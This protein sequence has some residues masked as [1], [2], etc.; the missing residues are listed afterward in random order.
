MG[1]YSEADFIICSVCASWSKA[2]CHYVFLKFPM[3]RG[4]RDL[5]L[6]IQ[7]MLPDFSEQSCRHRQDSSIGVAMTSL[8]QVQ[9]DMQCVTFHIF[10]F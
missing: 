6:A 7:C 8:L 3:T 5:V 10:L 4:P 1:V 9:N 2:V